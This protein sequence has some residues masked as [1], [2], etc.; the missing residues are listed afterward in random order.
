[1]PRPH[2]GPRSPAHRLRHPLRPGRQWTGHRHRHCQM[3]EAARTRRGTTCARESA[4]SEGGARR[5][6]QWHAVTSHAY[7]SASPQTRTEYLRGARVEHSHDNSPSQT[8]CSRR[9]CRRIRQDRTVALATRSAAAPAGPLPASGPRS[10]LARA[11][12]LRPGR[13][14]GEPASVLGRCP[15]RRPTRCPG[16]KCWRSTWSREPI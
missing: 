5:D 12:G 15:L 16:R 11:G 2:S 7:W 8:L 13:C 3:A 10:G 4:A 9:R 14:C 1:V 6:E